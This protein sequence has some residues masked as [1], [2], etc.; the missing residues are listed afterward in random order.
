MTVEL[1]KLSLLEWVAKLSDEQII[2]ELYN[3]INIKYIKQQNFDLSNSKSYAQLKSTKIDLD[4]IK[5]EQ[6][7]QGVDEEKMDELIG[8][9]DIEQSIEELLN[10]ID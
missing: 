6:N 3:S 7:Y 8:T 2:N 4:K 9:L 1:Q 10:D 5:K